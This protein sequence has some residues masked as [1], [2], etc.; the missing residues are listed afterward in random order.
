MIGAYKVLIRDVG[1]DNSIVS[2]IM[3]A[4]RDSKIDDA[5]V[6]M[7]D[8]PRWNAVFMNGPAK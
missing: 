1:V 6:P 5:L 8:G 7:T 2:R 4:E 3:N